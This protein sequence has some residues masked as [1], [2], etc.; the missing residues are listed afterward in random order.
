[1]CGD[2]APSCFICLASEGTLLRGCACRGTSGYVHAD[3][4][5][6]LNQ[7]RTPEENFTCP[8][9]KA[10]F[11]GHLKVG[12]AEGGV[13]SLCSTTFDFNAIRSLAEALCSQGQ[14]VEGLRLF[15]EVVKQ[16]IKQWG[17]H[18]P[19]IA[20]E[21]VGEDNTLSE[22]GKLEEALAIQLTAL[23]TLLRF[24]G[25]D[26]SQVAVMKRNIGWTLRELD[27]LPEA[28]EILKQ[29]LAI[30]EQV[31]GFNHPVVADTKVSF[32]ETNACIHLCVYHVKNL[33][34]RS[35]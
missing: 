2:E 11:F 31:Y 14:F 25:P 15:R 5:V 19:C 35:T 21:R 1:M 16:G 13:R 28:L 34:C 23:A 22:L 18:H 32:G 20:L 7:Y 6:D 10:A 9:C 29:G 26:H 33:M 4:I 12:V 27:R 3:C 30:N 24:F 17:P 8:T